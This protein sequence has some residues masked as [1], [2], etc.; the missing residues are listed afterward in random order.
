VK[1]APPS[2]GYVTKVRET[3]LREREVNLKQN[4]FWLSALQFCYDNGIDPGQILAYTD[5]IRALT[6]GLVQDAAR[7]YL[8][9]SRYARFILVPEQA[10]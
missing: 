3:E 1:N 10:Q 7:T 8:N 9:T 6:P 5:L 2:Q 4:G